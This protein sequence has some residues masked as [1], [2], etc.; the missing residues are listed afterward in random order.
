MAK[1]K[2][3]YI[4]NKLLEIELIKFSSSFNEEVDRIRKETKQS[5]KDAKKAATGYISEE[6]GTMFLQIAYNLIN[7]SNFNNYTYRD[8]MLGLGIEYM[9]RF[10]KNFDRT[11]TNANGFSYCTQI[12]FNG[13]IQAI[14]KEKKRSALK[15]DM[16]KDSMY[17]TELDKWNKSKL[18]NIER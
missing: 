14:T 15:D 17:D 8:E 13:F 9:C 5:L 2:T 4:D 6:L 16:I 3:N 11:K 1:E 18:N 12:C 7:K 10:A